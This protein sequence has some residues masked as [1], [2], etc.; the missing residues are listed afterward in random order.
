MANDDYFGYNP[1]LNQDLRDR[2]M[3][4]RR[5]GDDLTNYP[6]PSFSGEHLP[7]T[8]NWERDGRVLRT[9][10]EKTA[11]AND[12]I[13]KIR[14]RVNSQDA[15]AIRQL[16]DRWWETTLVLDDLKARVRGA[17]ETLRDGQGGGGGWQGAGADAFLARGP[18][19]T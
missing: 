8:R 6:P 14:K 13:E 1:A 9:N 16:A 19:A 10:E 11:Y 2:R 7:P 4:E 18:G 17:A 15:Q 5:T 12:S 3:W